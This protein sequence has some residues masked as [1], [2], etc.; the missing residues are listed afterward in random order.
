VIQTGEFVST[1]EEACDCMKHSQLFHSEGY[2]QLQ[3]SQHYTRTCKA[4]KHTKVQCLFQAENSAATLSSART[5]CPSYQS[6]IFAF[7]QTTSFLIQRRWADGI[8]IKPTYPKEQPGGM[9][10]KTKD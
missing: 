8:S 7:P 10:L 9:L 5:L 6:M 2:C 4:S 3:A 1:D